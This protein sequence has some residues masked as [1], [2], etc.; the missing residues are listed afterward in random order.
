MA[1]ENAPRTEI[2]QL[3]EFGLIEHLTRDIQL[4]NPSSRYGVGDDA[5][6]IDAGNGTVKLITTDMLLEGIHFDLSYH[7]LRHL[8]YKAIVVN[9]S[10]I[11]AM[12]GTP[13]QVT[14]SLGLSN[15]FSV[16]ALEELYAGIEAACEKYAVDLVGGDTNA[17]QSGLVISVTAVGT[18]KAEDVVYRHTAR[19]GDLVV[20]SGD[21]GAAYL[22]L[23]LLEREKKLF[24]EDP[25]LQPNLEDEK[26]IVGRQLLPEARRDIIELLDEVKVRPTAMIDISD[27]LSS[28]LMHIC[29]RSAVGCR[30]YE[31]EIPVAEETRAR[32]L[33][34]NM[35]P[36]TAALNGGEDYELLF[37]ID[38]TDRDRIASS[39]DLT[40]IGEIVRP[41]DGHKLIT[42]SGQAHPLVA[43][44][45]KHLS[46]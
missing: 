28:D 27:G 22:G 25:T 43:Q 5:A 12:N 41:K 2:S 42:R 26:Y 40:V 35:P 10:D 8:G 38:P 24:R 37:T 21:L 34:F 32:A 20:V 33:K 14:V 45:W 13:E 9:L 16:E 17:S 3:G 11:Y 4:R 46:E 6:V 7:P 36:S 1:K 39:V 23:Q 44:G 29:T 15:R 18:A 30:V 31:Q 19:H